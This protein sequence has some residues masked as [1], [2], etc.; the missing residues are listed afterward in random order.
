MSKLS[1]KIK[2]S[3]DGEDDVTLGGGFDFWESGAADS[4]LVADGGI[5]GLMD[6]VALGLMALDTLKK[7]PE[8]NVEYSL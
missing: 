6:S 3:K 4:F 5:D 8:Y 2:R 7:L 1:G